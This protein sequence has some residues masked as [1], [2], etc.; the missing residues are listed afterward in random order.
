MFMHSIGR[1][2]GRCLIGMVTWGIGLCALIGC[3]ASA[4]AFPVTEGF[5]CEADALC[6]GER[7]SGT[8]TRETSGALRWEM[9]A[10]ASVSGWTFLWDGE[11]LTLNLQGLSYV[12]DP[13]A[14]PDTAPVRVL[15]TAADAIARMD[16]QS[17]PAAAADGTG[18]T[19][20]DCSAGTFTLSSD[21]AT[22]FWRT[23]SVPESGVE[24]RF[25]AFAATEAPPPEP[26]AG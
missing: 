19:V 6:D 7:F 2:I 15:T 25:S 26:S 13:A 20:G 8:L 10:P 12:I 21:P 5:R 11:A 4:P 9:T 3:A 1:M 24:I 16:R 14:M 18:R 17:G 23:L 22:G